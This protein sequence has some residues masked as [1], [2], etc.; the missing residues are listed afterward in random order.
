MK[1]PVYRLDSL[2]RRQFVERSAKTALGVS[3]LPAAENALAQAGTG[4]AKN[5]IYMYMS[6][7]MTHIDTFD[8]KPGTETGGQTGVAPTPVS[9]EY[10][11]EYIPELAKRF[12]DI[13]VV[14]T[15]M[16]KTA[17]HQGASYWMRTSYQKRASISHP[18]LGAWAQRLLGKSHDTL[19]NSV[20]IGGGGGHP[21]AGF[22]GPTY[23]PLP[24]GSPTAGLPDS[25]RHQEVDEARFQNRLAALEKF[26]QSF[27]SRFKTNSVL[28]YNQFYDDTMQLMKS[29][30]LDV[31]DLNQESESTRARYGQDRFGQ[32]LLLAKRLVKQGI[33]YVEVVKGG[34]DM[35]NDLWNAIPQRAGDIDKAIAALIDD[36][37]AEGLFEETLL[38]LTTEFGR[39]PRINENGGRDHHSL[40]FSGMLAGGGIAGGQS[41]GVSDD[42]G[43]AAKDDLVE[44]KDFNAT[45]ASAC[46][47]SID[48]VVFSP[49][50]RPFMIAGHKEDLR[51]RKIIPEGKPITQLLS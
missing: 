42:K 45:I 22:L 35:H 6:G 15:L 51:T 24:L 12:K 21:G 9:G 7:G 10:L 16:Q 11:G 49:S 39:T 4:K 31:F 38:V 1:S 40:C 30:E 44:Q 47:M 46:G 28:A 36:L 13:A 27:T 32:G 37:K 14:R 50:G 29:D 48:E 33:R 25:I 34:W 19:P 18:C 43:Y 41:Y 2:S 5:I 20:V 23:S 3:L 26:N 8:P 17:D